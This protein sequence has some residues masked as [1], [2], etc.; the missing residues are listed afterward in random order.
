M[1]A[2]KFVMLIAWAFFAVVNVF[3]DVVC[4]LNVFPCVVAVDCNELISLFWVVIEFPCAV[5][6]VCSV[7]MEEACEAMDDAWFVS[8]AACDAMDDV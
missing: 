3:I 7:D 8:V 6:S 5:E 2:C 1:S 4:E